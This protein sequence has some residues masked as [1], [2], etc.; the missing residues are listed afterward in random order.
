MC[1]MPVH[2]VYGVHPGRFGME[3]QNDMK[4]CLKPLLITLFYSRRNE[5]IEKAA[6]I[7]WPDHSVNGGR[8]ATFKEFWDWLWIDNGDHV[9]GILKVLAALIKGVEK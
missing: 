7:L 8:P 9:Y 1:L 5:N 2:D 6:A 3:C 4:D